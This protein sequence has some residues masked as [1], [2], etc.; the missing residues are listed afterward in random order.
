MSSASE[1]VKPPM[2]HYCTYFDCQY[3]ERGLAMI[4]TLR[5]VDPGCMITVLCLTPECER[6]L[7]RVQE[8]Q[9]RLLRLQDFEH[10]NPDLLSVKG[11]RSSLEYYFTLSGCIV[12]AVLELVE[13]NDIVT[14]V[15]ADL[16]FYSSV[17]PIYEEMANASVGL[18][19]HRYHW[20][21]K[22]N[23]KF[24][25]FNV[26]WASFRCDAAGREAATWWHHRCV[27][28]C[29]DYVEGD[30]FAD[31]KYL[32]HIFE[33]FPK[34]IEITHPGANVAP[35]NIGRHAITKT[36]GGVLLVDREWP[37]IFFHFQGLKEIEPGFYLANHLPY[38]APFSRSLRLDLYQPYVNLLSQIRREIG[39]VPSNAPRLARRG[40]AK[41]SFKNRLFRLRSIML[42]WAARWAGH[43]VT[44]APL[45]GE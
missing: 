19:P 41:V 6:A 13:A 43:Y 22:H 33:R 9:V 29:H 15:D 2:H 45:E 27:E 4:R 20:W 14:Y 17:E 38:L 37:L 18:I 11:T 7:L 26:G 28:W 10:D 36:P 3:L 16:L 32:D 40:S 24:G 30:R 1:F 34:V 21:K 44:E 25:R 23:I 35:W 31:Q 12:T 8:P 39:G 5:R 42:R